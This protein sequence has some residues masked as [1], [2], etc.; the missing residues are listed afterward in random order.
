MVNEAKATIGGDVVSLG[1]TT[2]PQVFLNRLNEL[3]TSL[4]ASRR[5]DTPTPPPET[6]ARWT[7]TLLGYAQEA[8]ALGAFGRISEYERLKNDLTQLKY[9]ETAT[10]DER[11]AKLSATVDTLHQGA[12]RALQQQGQQQQL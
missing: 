3:R 12:T 6:L 2:G 7:D 9:N 11:M 5:D 8:S 10:P 4:D 1:V